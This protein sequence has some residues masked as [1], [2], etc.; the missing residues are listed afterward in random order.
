MP[1]ICKYTIS[2]SI[3]SVLATYLNVL[4]KILLDKF[5]EYPRHV[6]LLFTLPTSDTWEISGRRKHAFCREPNLN[7]LQRIYELLEMNQ[8]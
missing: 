2:K 6:F 3:S 7:V 8:Q 1:K 5:W 4:T